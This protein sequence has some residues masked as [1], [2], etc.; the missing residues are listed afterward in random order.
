[1]REP[2]RAAARRARGAGA[3]AAHFESYREHVG[4]GVEERLAL[5]EALAAQDA[6]LSCAL[7]DPEQEAPTQPT[8]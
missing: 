6:P 1:V 5:L 3:R 7:G 2:A 4:A 8:G